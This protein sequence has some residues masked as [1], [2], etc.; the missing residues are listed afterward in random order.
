[1]VVENGARFCGLTDVS[2]TVE[3]LG[4]YV[5]A[6]IDNLL[7]DIFPSEMVCNFLNNLAGLSFC[8][9]VK[10]VHCYTLNNSLFSSLW[11][12]FLTP[13]VGNIPYFKSLI[14]TYF[15]LF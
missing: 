3:D 15:G 10:F 6:S 13:V 1:V 11:V 7:D 8:C 14:R 2:F 5:P 4:T 9:C 12:I